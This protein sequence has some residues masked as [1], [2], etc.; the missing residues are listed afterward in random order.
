MY[1]YCDESCH[2]ENDK[3]EFMILGSVRLPREKKEIIYKEI[4][5]IKI[6]H[7]LSPKLEIKWIKVSMS[8][9]DFFEEIIDYFFQNKYLQFRAVVASKE[10]LK[11]RNE[12]NDDYATWYYKMYYQLL[13]KFMSPRRKNRIFLDIKDSRGGKRIKTLRDILIWE[14]RNKKFI[15]D[16]NQVHSNTSEVLQ[17][18][19]LLIGALGYYNRG[20]TTNEGKLRIVRKIFDYTSQDGLDITKTTRIAERKFNVFYWKGGTRGYLI[21]FQSL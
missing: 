11:F 18:T 9:I 7:G 1:Y 20:L 12:E 14:N 4:K 10:N 21:Y 15:E 16:I 3:I 17:L 6:K 19:D 5:N 2:L 8:K 13:N